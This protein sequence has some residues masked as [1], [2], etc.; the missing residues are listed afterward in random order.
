M[1]KYKWLRWAGLI[2]AIGVLM[3][4]FGHPKGNMVFTIGFVLFFLG[5]LLVWS[6]RWGRLRLA[7]PNPNQRRLQLLHFTL[8][9]LALIA[10]F[11][12]YQQYAYGNVLFVIALLAESLVNIRIRLNELVG[13]QT[14]NLGWQFLKQWLIRGKK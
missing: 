5:K 10:L 2:I 4:L 7:F 12:R 1:K 3:R 9:L 6:D 14:V 11:M 13:T 8:I